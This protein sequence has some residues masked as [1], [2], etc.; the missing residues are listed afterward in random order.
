MDFHGL[1]VDLWRYSTSASKQKISQKY[2]ENYS[3]AEA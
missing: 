1:L 3:W 2:V